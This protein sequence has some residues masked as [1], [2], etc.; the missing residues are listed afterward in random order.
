MP[1][2]SGGITKAVV[3][4]SITVAGVVTGTGTAHADPATACR[5][6]INGPTVA[7]TN[8][9]SIGSCCYVEGNGYTIWGWIP[10][11]NNSGSSVTYCA[12]AIDV[13]HGGW[14]HDFGCDSTTAAQQG[15]AH[16]GAADPYHKWGWQTWGAGPGT[17]VISAGFW[18]NGHYLGDVES[19]MTTIGAHA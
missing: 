13:I 1:D 19:P 10:Y 12:H 3:A 17:Y 6:G 18:L 11:Q 15:M 4:G 2:W 16:P 5:S 7:V 8:T 9:I 14:A